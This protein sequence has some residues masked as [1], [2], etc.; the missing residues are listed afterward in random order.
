MSACRTYHW[1]ELPADVAGGVR[2]MLI[3]GEGGDL[4]RVEIPAGTTADRHEH[5]HEQFVLVLEG[6]GR[7]TTA[8]GTVALRPGTVLHIGAGTWHAAV[9][10]TATVLIEVNFR[11]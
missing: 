10:E 5:P 2:R 8:E 1:D 3:A 6:T 11:R 4:K 7:L 9:F